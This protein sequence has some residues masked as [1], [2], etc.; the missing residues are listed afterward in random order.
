MPQVSNGK[1]RKQ[2]PPADISK[3]KYSVGKNMQY[4][5]ITNKKIQWNEVA[6]PKVK[7]RMKWFESQKRRPHAKS[8]G[9]I[10]TLEA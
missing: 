5:I 8:Y 1:L 10:A 6:K 4:D 7:T 2:R 9:I 3:L